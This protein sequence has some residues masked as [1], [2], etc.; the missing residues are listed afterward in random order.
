M[1]VTHRPPSRLLA[2]G[3]AVVALLPARSEGGR[4]AEAPATDDMKTVVPELSE[5]ASGDGSGAAIHF[6]SPNPILEIDADPI[7]HPFLQD[8]PTELR[9][10]LR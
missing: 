4:R 1:K 6:P 7:L 2:T 3:E 10:T 8:R 9:A 5:Q